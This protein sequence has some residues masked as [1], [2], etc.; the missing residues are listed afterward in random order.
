MTTNP[1]TSKPITNIQTHHH[2]EPIRTKPDTKQNPKHN[3][4]HVL[5][6]FI[7]IILVIIMEQGVIDGQKVR[8]IAQ[9]DGEEK[10][11]WRCRWTRGGGGV[12]AG[13]VAGF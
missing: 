2:R 13:K 1:V 6:L 5:F 3:T 11:W 7:V 9:N 10:W 12:M 4:K 8:M